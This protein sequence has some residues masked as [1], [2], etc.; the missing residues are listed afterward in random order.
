LSVAVATGLSAIPTAF[1]RRNAGVEMQVEATLLPNGSDIAV[2]IDARHTEFT[3]KASVYKPPSLEFAQPGFR[4]L[5]VTQSMQLP[6]G[7][8]Y[9]LGTAMVPAEVPKID[10]FLFH[11]T[12]VP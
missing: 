4:T 10:L 6:S 9:L 3:G 5:H 7:C 8:W 1:D 2:K 11:V 12:A